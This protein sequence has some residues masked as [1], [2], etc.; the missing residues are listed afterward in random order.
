M[1]DDWDL[2]PET[3]TLL[4]RTYGP[5]DADGVPTTVV[6]EVELDGYNVQPVGTA[7]SVGLERVVTSRWRVSG[8]LT[9][10]IRAGD[11][12]RWKGREYDVDGD[13]QHYE[14]GAFD[15]TEFIIWRQE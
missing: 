12:V 9:D 10:Q 13:P 1:W 14:G 4:R 2:H 5:P 6:E 15:H 8:P 11:R 3:V 7:E